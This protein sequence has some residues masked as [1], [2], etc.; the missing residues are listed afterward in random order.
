MESDHFVVT[1]SLTIGTQ[2]EN[3]CTMALIDCGATR[4]SFVDERFVS[5]HNLPLH[6]LQTPRNLEVINGRPIE[7]GPINHCSSFDLHIGGHSE[8]LF[9]FITTLGQYPLVL[10]IPWMHHHDITTQWAA[11][12]IV[13]ESDHCVG[14]HC[15]DVVSVQGL[16]RIPTGSTSIS[17][18]GRAPME[19]LIKAITPNQRYDICSLLEHDRQHTGTNQH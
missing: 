11:N 12:M 5:L 13:F 4:Y 17:A 1:C 14:H 9:A 18:I 19:T 15:N 6:T 2:L 16:S 3:I 10:S 7:S 8:S